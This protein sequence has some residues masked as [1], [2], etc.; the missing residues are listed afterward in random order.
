MAERPETEPVET[1]KGG[2]SETNPAS[3]QDVERA[4]E[5]QELLAHSPATTKDHSLTGESRPVDLDDGEGPAVA[6]EGDASR[7]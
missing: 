4:R 5:Q 2:Y 3:S 1:V 6:D 7:S